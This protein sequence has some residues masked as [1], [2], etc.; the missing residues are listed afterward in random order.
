M[1]ISTATT[2]GQILTS[3]Y[4]NNNINSGMTYVTGA[5]FSAVTEI[6]LDSVF[7][8]TYRNYYLVF[9]CQSSA[10]GSTFRWQVRSGG[11]TIST[12]T[13][14]NQILIVT[15]TT[16]VPSSATGETQIRIGANDASG[17]HAMT[18]DIF[19]PQVAQPTRF[20]SSFN[21]NN[22][23]SLE[24]TYGANT[25]STSYDGMRISVGAGTMTGSYALYGYRN[26]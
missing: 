17:Y 2:P 19:C 13:Y 16:M 4:V 10:G 8:S 24:N 5:S 12:A 11:S 20:I 3:A 22:G 18:M 14:N 25:N 21:R 1:A 7:T 15:N 23:A 26:A 6:L 9:D